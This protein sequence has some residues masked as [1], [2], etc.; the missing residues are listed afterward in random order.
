MMRPASVS[1]SLF[2]PAHNTT[3]LHLHLPN[4]PQT[5]LES[6]GQRLC[7]VADGQLVA[8]EY[9]FNQEQGLSQWNPPS[10][11]KKAKLQQKAAVVPRLAS[12][13]DEEDRR[14]QKSVEAIA[15]ADIPSG[16]TGEDSPRSS[17]KEEEEDQGGM[18]GVPQGAFST[19]AEDGD[20]AADGD[21]EE[22]ADDQDDY[23]DGDDAEQQQQE[24]GEKGNS[25]ADGADDD[26]EDEG[27]DARQ[28][29]ARQ[30]YDN[31]DNAEEDSGVD[32]S[33]Q[34]QQIQQQQQQQQQADYDDIMGDEGDSNANGGG[35]DDGAD[36]D[37]GDKVPL[38][39]STSL[40]KKPK[41]QLAA[42]EGVPGT[43]D[44]ATIGSADWPS[45][46]PGAYGD[47]TSWIVGEHREPLWS[48][49]QTG[50]CGLTTPCPKGRADSGHGFQR[51][52][53]P[54]ADKRRTFDPYAQETAEG[55]SS[56][57]W[58]PSRDPKAF[59]TADCS[60]GKIT[61]DCIKALS[62]QEVAKKQGHWRETYDD[63]YKKAA[64]AEDAAQKT[65]EEGS[66]KVVAGVGSMLAKAEHALKT[67]DWAPWVHRKSLRRREGGAEGKPL[68]TTAAK[69]AEEAW[70]KVEE[71]KQGFEELEKEAQKVLAAKKSLKEEGEGAKGEMLAD[72]MFGLDAAGQ[73]GGK[74]VS[75]WESP[76]AVAKHGL[77]GVGG[78]TSPADSVSGR[79][80]SSSSSSHDEE[81]KHAKKAAER[82]EKD[83][84]ET[85]GEEGPL[86]SAKTDAAVVERGDVAKK[87][88][89]QAKARGK[90][91][92]PWQEKGIQTGAMRRESTQVN[93][94]QAVEH[95]DESLL[96]KMTG[97]SGSTLKVG[98]EYMHIYSRI[99]MFIFT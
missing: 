81:T 15:A 44:I 49:S 35:G 1:L 90:S 59:G 5:L 37:D 22:N 4:P 93:L 89:E 85:K 13:E 77:F 48:D 12:N 21:E 46:L 2:A 28:Q 80:S 40:P 33:R 38:S 79:S 14:I 6:L 43:G 50:S 51:T 71:G 58:D 96:K 75:I 45:E 56:Y 17:A 83:E 68:A 30:Q 92:K 3:C 86:P 99:H 62:A 69:V 64:A 52:T 82:E 24:E 10:F 26:H 61:D 8:Q 9:Y 95:H 47:D 70:E 57:P 88:A 19:M 91:M 66:K 20:D 54:F 7:R 60:D 97:I 94:D 98:K 72:D 23:A 63:W 42:P 84:V 41:Q 53:N 87:E 16:K 55:R 32:D 73:G 39:L 29:I 36:A 31:D 76:S 67:A 11:V 25:A 74:G 18:P 78:M 27:Q 34:D 65:A